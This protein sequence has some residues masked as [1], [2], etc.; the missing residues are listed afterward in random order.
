MWG[1]PLQQSAD[2][3]WYYNHYLNVAAG[4]NLVCFN[5]RVFMILFLGFSLV[6]MYEVVSIA[7]FAYDIYLLV[8]KSVDSKC[9]TDFVSSCACV[10]I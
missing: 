1:F 5:S 2:I 7:A 9:G 4:Y 10:Y 6:V 3:N 8:T